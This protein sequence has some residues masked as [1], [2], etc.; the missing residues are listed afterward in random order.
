MARKKRKIVMGLTRR[1]EADVIDFIDRTFGGKD[2]RFRAE[3]WMAAGYYIVLA[4]MKMLVRQG[5][6]LPDAYKVACDGF[7]DLFEY[8]M[9]DFGEFRDLYVSCLNGDAS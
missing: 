1:E 6:T 4:A 2:E 7:G 3:Q 9:A 8:V 5:V